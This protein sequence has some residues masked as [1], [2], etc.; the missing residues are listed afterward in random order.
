MDDT[1]GQHVATTRL[2]VVLGCLGAFAPLAVDMYL[3][4]WPDIQ[5][6][7]ETSA[8][9]V[10]LTLTAFLLGISLGQ[11]VAGPLSDRLGRRLPLLAGVATFVLASVACALA[12]SIA[13]LVVLRFVQGFA[14]GAGI[15]VGRAIVRDLGDGDDAARNFSLLILVN[16]IGPI[17]APIAGGQLLHVTD[18]RGIF[19]VLAGAALV[20]LVVSFRV[21]PETR[22][23]GARTAGG[24][25]AMGA[26][27]REVGRDRVFLGYAL[28][29]GLVF[30]ALLAYIAGSSFVLQDLYGLS[31]Q[32]FSAFF[33]ANGLGLVA[34]TYVNGRLIGRVTPHTL[35]LVG[36]GMTALGAAVLVVNVVVPDLPVGAILPAF[37]LIVTSIG[38]VQPNA[39]TLA[40]AGHPRVAGSASALLGLLQSIGGAIVA[41]LVGIAGTGTA[42]P[43]AIVVATLVAGGW[44]ALLLTR[45]PRHAAV[46]APS[47]V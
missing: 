46:E 18:W 24:L 22:P 5:R 12:P 1:R 32:A 14:G 3:P 45:A 16:N 30:S 28:S 34:A 36:M 15:A 4:G 47:V 13:A 2:M 23:A 35:L 6:T 33:A 19:V 41:P 9:A 21:V 25:G 20:L 8:S 31:P 10:Q 39:T 44:L 26:A 11:L 38:L 17:V 37:L 29:S 40:M 27:L 43:L 7:L 42:V